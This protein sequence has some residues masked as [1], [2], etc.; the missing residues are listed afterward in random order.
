MSKY[1][2]VLAFIFLLLFTQCHKDPKPDT[3]IL[4]VT[5]N[6]ITTKYNVNVYFSGNFDP[7]GYAIASGTPYS[8]SFFIPS[9][10]AIATSMISNDNR[11]WNP[12][13]GQ[14]IN[15]TY[16]PGG[17]LFEK[18]SISASFKNLILVVD[19]PTGSSID[20]IYASANIYGKQ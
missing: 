14:T 8:V 4:V 5:V 1:L 9:S 12:V 20:T 2:F 11:I 15:I 18:R 3:N 10:T 16:N 13:K 7:Y 19:K 6:G 17:S